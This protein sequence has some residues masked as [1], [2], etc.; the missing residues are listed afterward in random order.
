LSPA[1]RQT[2]ERF[3]KGTASATSA[4]VALTQDLNSL[5]LKQN[6][7]TPE[8]F[9]GVTLQAKTQ[10]LL[11]APAV[12]GQSPARL[13]RL[14]LADAY[15]KE[16]AYQD[17]VVGITNQ[18]AASMAS[19]GFICFL[20]GRVS[21]AALLGIRSAHQVVGIY[22]LLNVAACLLVFFK[23]GWLSFACVFLSYFF[24]SIMF[25][26]I[27]ALG[28]YGLGNRAKSASAYI[29][30]GIMGGAMLPK[31]MGSVA[32]HYDMSRGF[33]VPMLCFVLIAL[34]GF[35]WPKLSGSAAL[36]GVGST[37]GH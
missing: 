13:N 20:L 37:G 6:F 35:A 34:Y 30:M 24:M 10:A 12:K 3:A 22:A 7:H 27:F 11:A 26:T 9:N 4:R 29:V 17:G 21:G 2:L 31:V 25:P 23:L 15:P 1:T 32:D 28:I 8:R 18:L 16:L 14:L 19:F 5:I 33:I 36:H